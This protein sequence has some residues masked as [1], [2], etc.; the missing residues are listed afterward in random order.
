MKEVAKDMEQV[1]FSL[2]D[3]TKGAM[4]DDFPEIYYFYKHKTASQLWVNFF[5]EKGLDTL[6]EWIQKMLRVAQNHA[7]VSQIK[8]IWV[9]TIASDLG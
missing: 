9:S 2:A 3:C 5:I 8:N 6:K 4:S 7:C 1:L